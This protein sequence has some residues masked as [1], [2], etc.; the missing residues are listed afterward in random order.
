MTGIVELDLRM[1]KKKT[2]MSKR[3]VLNENYKGIVESMSIPAEIHERNG[4][5]YA[6]VGSILPIHCCPPEEL[7]RRAEST[8]HYCGVFTDELLAPLE[9]L[10]YVRLDEN[11]AEKVFINRAKRILIVSSDG[12]LAQ[13]RC[14]PTFESANR[15]IAGTPIVDQRGGVI[16]VVV[17]K[18]NNHYAVSSFEGEGGYFEST[19]NWKVVEPAAGGYAYGEL[20][21]PS[22]TA[23]RE[24]V[25]GL[26]GGAGAWGDAVPVLRGGTSPRLALVLDG[27]QLAHYYLHNVIV[28][29][30]YL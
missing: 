4:K 21:F 2:A 18:K 8:H 13:W 11:T 3:T 26:R 9:E 27:R 5:K 25:A 19:Q 24:H 10:A 14:A 12:H 28:D 7:E 6:S 22:R 23:L 20:T 1:L 29:V 15:Y 16:S 17:A 30:E